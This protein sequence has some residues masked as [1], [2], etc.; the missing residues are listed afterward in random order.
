MLCVC[1]NQIRQRN[2]PKWN[3]PG[4]GSAYHVARLSSVS[5]ICD[6]TP[7]IAKPP[8]PST[9]LFAFT[10]AP[11]RNR[12]WITPVAK[13]T[14]GRW[15]LWKFNIFCCAVFSFVFVKCGTGSTLDLYKNARLGSRIIQTRYGRLQG[16]ILPLD[17]YKFLRPIE[18]YL[19]VP[20]ATP[21]TQS[22]R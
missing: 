20:Y 1:F 16:L 13:M 18:A 19:G 7:A 15:N 21:P 9:P 11:T 2:C 17:S 5:V 14:E 3:W 22:N 12:N 6:W 4:I 8:L 10:A